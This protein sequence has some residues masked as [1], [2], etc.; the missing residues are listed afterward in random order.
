MKEKDF[1]VCALNFQEA[2]IRLL[3]ICLYRS[4]MGDFTYFLNHLELVLNKLY[5]VSTHI[6][7][8]G[9]VNVHFLETTSTVTL[10]ESVLAYLVRGAFKF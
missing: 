8:C 5:R 3:I 4:P 6:T 10:L 9:D 7:V 1:E 2:S